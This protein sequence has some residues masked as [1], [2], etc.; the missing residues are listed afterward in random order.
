M[1]TLIEVSRYVTLGVVVI[2]LIGLLEGIVWCGIVALVSAIWSP[3][4]RSRITEHEHHRV[5]QQEWGRQ[6]KGGC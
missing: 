5:E 6:V 1:G 4:D 3:R 2:L